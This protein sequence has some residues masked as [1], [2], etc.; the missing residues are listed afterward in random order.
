MAHR[1]Y[2][3]LKSATSKREEKAV[4]WESDEQHK[5]VSHVRA[6]LNFEEREQLGLSLSDI[7]E[8]PLRHVRERKMRSFTLL[9]D[10][11]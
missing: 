6:G 2:S 7:L 10:V 11:L 9:L 3:R 1:K 4:P 5:H 8:W